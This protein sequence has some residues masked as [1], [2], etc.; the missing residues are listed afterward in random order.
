M[1]CG[2]Q[3]R[4][5]AALLAAAAVST[6]AWAEEDDC[7]QASRFIYVMTAQREL[8]RFHPQR[9]SFE[10]VG[11]LDCGT[12]PNIRPYS[13]AVG[14]D[15]TAWVVMSD[16]SLY[17]AS[18]RD[19]RCAATGFRTGQ[20]GFT[21]FGM[22]FARDTATQTDH[23]YVSNASRIGGVGHK[24]AE[25]DTTT[26][27]L[28]DIGVDRELSARAELTGPADGHLFGAFEGTPFVIAELDPASARIRSQAP[29]SGVNF[30]HNSA[31]FAFAFWGGDFY[32]FVGPGSTTEVYRYDPDTRSTSHL[33]GTRLTIV[34][35]G[36]ST[37]A[38][39]ELPTEDFTP[40]QQIAPPP[41]TPPPTPPAPTPPPQRAAEIAAIAPGPHPPGEDLTVVAGVR[42]DS[43]G[44]VPLDGG[45]FHVTDSS[46]GTL[47]YPG[48]PRP[49]GQVEA[50]IP[51]TAAGEVQIGFTPSAA[52]GAGAT[53]ARAR[54]EVGWGLTVDPDFPEK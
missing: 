12:R 51:L 32:L 13:M 44:F 3:R 17:T 50:H 23:L 15:G 49:D 30:A 29:Q 26:L 27:T 2:V 5:T 39:G 7:T 52:S 9:G 25:L 14:R 47:D 53:T 16:G 10:K 42:D 8:H 33:S 21:T 46:G 11:T 34:G 37:C 19:A 6:T 1:Q 35:A 22:G 41:S 31:N 4:R 40:R 43:G 18:T 45:T 38:P 54:V 24:L 36:V 48:T 20:S 28:R